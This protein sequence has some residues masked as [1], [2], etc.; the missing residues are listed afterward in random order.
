MGNDIAKRSRWTV[1]I[2]L[3]QFAGDEAP[4]NS[5]D[6]PFEW[7]CHGYEGVQIP[8]FEPG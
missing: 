5:L 2:F 8:T 3:A 1:A 7:A 6:A 4:F